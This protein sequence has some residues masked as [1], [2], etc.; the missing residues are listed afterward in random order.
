MGLVR[1]KSEWLCVYGAI[2]YLYGY[3]LYEHVIMEV[4]FKMALNELEN[5]LSRQV[6]A[7]AAVTRLVEATNGMVQLL[8]NTD[9]PEAPT[10]VDDL[11][12]AVNAACRAIMGS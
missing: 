9:R 8:T 10:L 7:H 1:V 12:A 5:K 6:G 3:H 11:E 2:L 4:R